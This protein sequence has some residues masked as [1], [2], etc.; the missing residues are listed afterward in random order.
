MRAITNPHVKTG[1]AMKKAHKA[2]ERVRLTDAKIRKTFA[3]L[4][5]KEVHRQRYTNARDFARSFQRCGLLEP[6]NLTYSAHSG[7]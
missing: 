3:N 5:L 2:G 7:V 1:G 6:H 4:G